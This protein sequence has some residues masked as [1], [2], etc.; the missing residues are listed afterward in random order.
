MDPGPCVLAAPLLP[1][2]NSQFCG[3]TPTCPGLCAHTRRRSPRD[4]SSATGVHSPKDPGK[5]GEG[6]Q[7]RSRQ[8]YIRGTGP[9]HPEEN[10]G[11]RQEDRKWLHS[12]ETTN[13][14]SERKSEGSRRRHTPPK[15]DWSCV[16]RNG[17]QRGLEN[18]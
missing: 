1:A 9:P 5:A 11:K 15:S 4:A 16:T 8:G 6:N 13:C 10:C 7:R 3:V 14:K 17:E 18:A 2:R 12:G